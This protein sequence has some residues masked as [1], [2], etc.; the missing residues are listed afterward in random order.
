MTGKPLALLLFCLGCVPTLAVG[1]E[2]Q[3]PAR[4]EEYAD[5][6]ERD[7]PVAY[8]RFETGATADPFRSRAMG[9][10]TVAPGPA[11]PEFPAF[12]DQQSALQL[13]GRSWLRIEDP[14]ASSAFDFDAGDSITLEAWVAPDRLPGGYSYVIGKGRTY[15]PGMVKE[16]H[17]WAMRLKQAA[18]GARLTFLF[19]SRGAGGAYHRWESK[20]GFAVGDGWHHIAIACTFGQKDSLRGYIDGE[21]VSGSWDLGGATDR[22]PVVDDD[23]VWIGSA[24]GGNAG[25]MFHGRLDEIAIHRRILPA[26]RIRSRYQ[27]HA[28]S[29]P[30][31]EVPPGR[32]LVEILE[33]VPSRDGW[34][35]RALKF[36]ESYVAD[37]FAFPEL[38]RRYNRCGVQ[39]SRPTPFLLRAHA[40]VVLPPGKQRILIRSREASRLF[41]DDTEV[42]R[43]DFYAISADA[44][45]PIWELDRSHAPNIRALRRGDRQ[46][47]IEVPGDGRPHR[48]RFEV[49][50]GLKG[51][52]PEMGDASVSLAGPAGDFQVISFAELVP[53]TE[54]GW[55]RFAEQHRM[56]L[57]ALNRQRRVMA[58][59]EETAWWNERHARAAEYI[60]RQT[61]HDR[62]LSVDQLV[63]AA[64]RSGS[65]RAAAPLSDLAFLRRVS[66][67]IVGRVPARSE[68]DRFLAAPTESRRADVIDWLL[69]D[70][71]WADHWV[72]YW[73]D[74]LAENPNIVNPSLNNTGPFRWWI[75]ESFLDN[76]AFD[77][78]VTELVL[79][80]GAV[81]EGGPGGFALATE[82]DVPMASRA[83]VLGQAFLGL[84]MRCARCHDAP[85]H[86]VRQRDL[87]SMA[88]MLNRQP[89]AVPL[90]SSINASPDVLDRMQVR[91]TL[92]PGEQVPPEWSF[93]QLISG[94]VPPGVLRRPDDSRERAA[95]LLTLPQNRRF[96]EVLVNRLWH[97]YTGRGLVDSLD[98]WEGLTPSHPE[99]LTWLGREFTVSGCDVRHVARLILQSRFYQS[100]P[101]ADARQLEFLA[102]PALRP[103]S[104]E[105]LVDSMF[106]VSEKAFHAG[107]IA[108]DIDGAR[109]AT[110]SLNLGE[111]RRA[112]MLTS[113]SNERDRP[114]LALPFAEPFVTFLE[115]FG[116]RGARQNP[117]NTRPDD[118]TALQP[119]EFLN[120]I[121]ARRTTR[122]SDDHAFTDL[123]LR[124]DL[125]LPELVDEIFL[126]VLTRR[127]TPSEKRS[128]R[129]LLE[130]G[131]DAR[132]R[133]D[134]P[135]VELPP[136]RRGMVSW[137]NHLEEEASTI[138]LELQEVVRR[139]DPPTRRLD[140]DWRERLEDVVWSLLNSPEFRFSP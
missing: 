82:N 53:L 86:D 96:A 4:A 46:R 93:S 116:W 99:L 115:Q 37:V 136:D 64:Q 44:N 102:G 134:E 58:S 18:G 25:S 66:L 85:A 23:E 24:M 128:V 83:H 42:G 13:D 120:G 88:A 95:V 33:N 12:P 80:E 130:R 140:P 123:A 98:D 50:V 34:E 54:P 132:R 56:W 8:W 78:F 110:L 41:L 81:Y 36:G 32:I 40:D 7:E 103:L 48:L 118:L 2:K 94:S 55:R 45:G 131:F 100:A 75:H 22:A 30:V 1:Q 26:D 43:T 97:R 68:I 138:K 117:V 65:V 17:N 51:R 73:Q 107:Q 106:T 10:P 19:R 121:L 79:M 67:D 126:R 108:L 63:A 135:L 129:Q 105:Q 127:P 104:A 39:V 38:P 125:E 76:R 92:K 133:P 11:A 52:R 113:T 59:A 84:Q 6:V 9:R 62:S 5:E 31:V 28:P 61:S 112:W 69:Q 71:G 137:S 47:V 60:R 21:P 139:G 14:G 87:F 70:E 114:G 74:V 119:A 111:P 29:L 20:E 35:F 90:S 57:A 16:N 72:G 15:L 109:P 101:V 89:L 122:L 27:Y 77:R 3:S 49:L 124:A 91:V